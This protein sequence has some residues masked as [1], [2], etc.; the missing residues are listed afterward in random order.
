MN[1]LDENIIASQRERL[2]RWRIP[3][4]Q[5]GYEIASAG[6]ADAQIIPV[7]L[8]LKDPTFLTRDFDFFKRRFCHPNYCI[9]WLNVRPDEA[10]FY[11][12]R[13]VRQAA[14]ATRKQRLGKVIRVHPGGILFYE[15][16]QRQ[17][18]QVAWND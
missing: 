18:G 14:F 17:L 9:V 6:T 16:L 2:R 10:A 5:I 13:L 1:V 7:L 4:R 12:R 3:F 8:R 11:T 15:R